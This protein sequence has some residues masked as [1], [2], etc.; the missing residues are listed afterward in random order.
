MHKIYVTHEKSENKRLA[1]VPSPIIVEELIAIVTSGTPFVDQAAVLI[2]LDET[3]EPVAPA[4]ELHLHHIHFHRCK[5]IN[6]TA[7]YA[8]KLLSK[9]FSPNAKIESI[10]KWALEAFGLRGADAKNKELHIHSA[11]GPIAPLENK[12][13]MYVEYHTE[14]SVTVFLTPEMGYQGVC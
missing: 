4:Q 6:V 1:E 11:S 5:R 2:F 12:I 13:G 3:E 9:E 7:N 14:C 8:G 10:E